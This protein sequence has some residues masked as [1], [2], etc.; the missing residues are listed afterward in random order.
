MLIELV[1]DLTRL[2]LGEVF[3]QIPEICR[4]SWS[5]LIRKVD[6]F[7]FYPCSFSLFML[8]NFE[9]GRSLL[10]FDGIMQRYIHRVLWTFTKRKFH[11]YSNR[12][13]CSAQ[14][15]VLLICS[16]LFRIVSGLFHV[17]RKLYNHL[18]ILSSCLLLFKGHHCWDRF[19][20]WIFHET[21]FRV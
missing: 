16:A 7:C 6:I 11:I 15:L 17:E 21:D 3:D 19:R 18:D 14:N 5:T 12:K 9:N 8:V 2:P 20:Q 4:T 10:Q 1:R 13:A